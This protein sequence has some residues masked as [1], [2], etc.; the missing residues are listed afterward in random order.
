MTFDRADALRRLADEHFDVLVVGG[1]IT[2]A[3][4]A[5]DAAT[6]GL[7]D[8]ARRQGRL[9]VGHVVEVVEARARRH[10]LPPAEGSRPR[11][12]SAG[13]TPDRCARPR[14]TSCACCRSC[15]RCS[16]ATGCSRAGS[17]GC[18][19]RR[20][21][22][23]TSPAACASASCT[24]ASRRTRRSRYMPTLPADRRRRVVHLL[25]R[26]GRRRAPHARRS[27]APRPTTAP[28]SRT[29]R[30][31]S[32]STRTPTAACTRR[33]SCGRRPDDRDPRAAVVVNA[34]GV[35][36]DDVRALDEGTHP[37]VD[38][39][40]QGHP[41]HRA[42]V[43]R[44][45][46]RSR[47][48]SRC[49]RTGARCSS[50]RGAARAASYAFTYIGTTDTDYDGPLDDPQITPDDV[51]Y[52]LARDQRRGHDARSPRPTSS[53]RGPGCARSSAAA[54]SE[55]T[56][57]L[58]PAALRAHLRQRRDHG[59][60]RQAHDVP[61]HGGRRGRRGRWSSSTAGGRSRTKRVQLHGADG[62]GR[63]RPPDRL[64]PT[65]YGADAR[66]RARARARRPGPRRADRSRPRVPR[67]EV[68]YAVR[69]EMART[70][71]DVLSR[72]TRARL[73]ARDASA[74]GRRRRRRADGRRARL[75]RR[76]ARTARSSTTGR[77]STTERH[78]RRPARDRARRA[79][80]TAR[81]SP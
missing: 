42:V 72:R 51:E 28:R 54:K 57:D 1:G 56:A 39:P 3:G 5:L 76:R 34:T 66:E 27:R 47:R 40:G 26:A 2:G 30:R 52:L 23:T 74:D 80:A 43:A 59:H 4:V 53:A 73:L 29:T 38:P 8:G 46:T 11:L 12:R 64:W 36:S 58:S 14:R 49:R 62:L 16:R 9:R 48:W 77:W 69:A 10:P 60:R 67:A 75:E 70:V 18:S 78:G 79:V 81:R 55:R 20:C 37:D 17:R 13:R 19:A 45:A 35:W 32:A 68:V 33:A 21:G 44:A 41:H 24:S 25:R 7:R 6:R 50:C 22:R 31:S 63:A 15:S 61:A 65:R 71:D